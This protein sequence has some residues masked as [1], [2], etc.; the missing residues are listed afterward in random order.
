MY[1]QIK[2]EITQA[3]YVQNFPN[4]GQRF[5][6]WYV[7]N[8]HWLDQ[9]ETKYAV[10]DGA[11]DKQ[12]DAIVIDE[13]NST[14]Y[15]IQGKFVGANKV[16][17]EPLREVLSSWVQLKSLVSL[18]ETAN[19]KLKQRLADLALAFEDE[20]DIAFEL[21]TT[22]ELTG[23]AKKD[24]AVFQRELAESE[25]LSAS[26]TVINEAE[27]QRRYELALER[28]NPLLKHNV[29]LET[30]RYLQM[31]IAE[32]DVVLAA[33]P[34]SDCISFPGIKD[35]SLFQKNVRQ[36]LGL[37]NRVNKGIKNSIYSDRHRDF[38][39]YHNGITAIEEKRS[40]RKCRAGLEFLE[41]LKLNLNILNIALLRA[42]DQL[43]T[44]ILIWQ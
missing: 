26:L 5:V 33:I 9:N 11:D 36:S 3:Y 27:L 13:E 22:A 25:D 28:D 4:D 6:A 32:T 40:G 24:L 35:G 42:D 19:A 10:T 31:R 2:E 30:G 37:N 43:E 41:V 14:A 18:Q 34:L 38:F 39:F 1:S 16:D 8:I 21:I 12:I 15:I 17:A 44:F 7:R 20:Y 23:A 29:K